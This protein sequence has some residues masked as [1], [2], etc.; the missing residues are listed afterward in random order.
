[1]SAITTKSGSSLRKEPME[2]VRFWAASSL[3]AG[4]GTL[5]PAC[6]RSTSGMG[7]MSLAIWPARLSFKG[8]PSLALFFDARLLAGSFSQEIELTPADV[9]SR[10]N[11]D[12]RDFRGMHRQRPLHADSKRNF[13]NRKGLPRARALAADD[14]PL[15]NLDP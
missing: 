14:C 1:M 15:E 8:N 7:R 5:G 13:P 10:K 4:T 11:L 9:P 6:A 3:W 12:L 2:P